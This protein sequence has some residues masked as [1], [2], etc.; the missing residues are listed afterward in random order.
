HG[1]RMRQELLSGWGSLLKP[2][3][4]RGILCS[5]PSRGQRVT[6]QRSVDWL[7]P[8]TRVEP[9]D[10]LRLVVRRYLHAYGPATHADFGAWWGARVDGVAGATGRVSEGRKAGVVVS[11]EPFGSMTKAVRRAVEREAARHEPCLGPIAAVR[12]ELPEGARVDEP[13]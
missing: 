6:F 4:Y 3:A 13:A 10:G 11:V 2:A 5:G 12:F 7:G 1:P 8:W 9:D